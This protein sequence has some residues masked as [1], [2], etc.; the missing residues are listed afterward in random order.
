M[1]TSKDG[2]LALYLRPS[3][4][5]YEMGIGPEGSKDRVWFDGKG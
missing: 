3:N 4:E 2:T 5:G 1:H